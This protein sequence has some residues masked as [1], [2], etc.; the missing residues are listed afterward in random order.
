VGG[1]LHE[2]RQFE[3]ASSNPGNGEEKCVMAAA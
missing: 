2:A 3:A 1:Q